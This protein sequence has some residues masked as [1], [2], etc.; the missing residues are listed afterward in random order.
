MALKKTEF[1]DD[2]E[3]LFDNVVIYKR[4]EVIPP[5]SEGFRSRVMRPWPAAVSG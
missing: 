1:K 2:E 5:F 4:G 3:A